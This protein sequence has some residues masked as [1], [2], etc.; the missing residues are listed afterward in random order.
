[1]ELAPFAGRSEARRNRAAGYSWP[2]RLY[3][4]K[5]QN[6]RFAWDIY[7]PTATMTLLLVDPPATTSSGYAPGGSCGTRKVI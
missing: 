1:M 7:R 5:F 3:Q 6:S 4:D 2:P